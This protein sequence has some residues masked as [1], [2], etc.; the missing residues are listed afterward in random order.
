MRVRI[1]S[2][3]Y[4]MGGSWCMIMQNLFDLVFYSHAQSA[5]Q[6]SLA[7]LLGVCVCV[8]ACVRVCVRACVRACVRVHSNLLFCDLL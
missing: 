2:N 1:P 7:T 8:C 3:K 6:I 4:N 5:L